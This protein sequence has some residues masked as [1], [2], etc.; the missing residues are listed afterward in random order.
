M[1]A[2][3]RLQEEDGSF[4]VGWYYAFGKTNIKIGHRGLTCTLSTEAI[5][6][7]QNTT[8]VY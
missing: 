2:L 3:L 5:K 6:A 7:Y 8:E 1:P 4:G